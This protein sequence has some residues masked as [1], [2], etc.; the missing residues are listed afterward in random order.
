MTIP[1]EELKS[2]VSP[3]ISCK[4][5]FEPILS[6]KFAERM[7]VEVTKITKAGFE[8]ELTN[9]PVNLRLVPGDKVYFE[10][11]HILDIGIFNDEEDEE[12]D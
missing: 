11:K 3:G 9:Q 1:D 4:L 2:L 10:S 8:G 7:W 6:Y 5:C 12:D